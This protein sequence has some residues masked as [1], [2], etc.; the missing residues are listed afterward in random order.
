[1][2][3]SNYAQKNCVGFDDPSCQNIS[4]TPQVENNGENL[5]FY[6][7]DAQALL[8]LE[9]YC[10]YQQESA[11]KY[12]FTCYDGR[13]KQMTFSGTNLQ[14]LGKD[15]ILPYKGD[16]P[17]IEVKTSF[18]T[19]KIQIDDLIN[20]AITV[21]LQKEIDI[22]NAIKKFVRKIN[23]EEYANDCSDGGTPVNPP[24]GLGSWDDAMV[25]WLWKI[26]SQ[27]PNVLCSGSSSGDPNAC[28]CRNMQTDSSLWE[29]DKNFCIINDSVT[30]QRVLNNLG[31]GNLYRT[32]GFGN[33]LTMSILSD[34][35]GNP[36][37]CPPKA[38]RVGYYYPP[39]FPKVRIGIVD[40]CQKSVDGNSFVGTCQW[41]SFIDSYT[42]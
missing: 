5:V 23:L 2:S 40:G 14:T 22:V 10:S 39:T 41:Y 32:D 3:N 36:Q 29:T 37:G 31:L 33:K 20:Y 12:V 30:W 4:L 7:N 24:N 42:E 25:P 16:Y 8:P 34:E 17:V 18:Y 26:V 27:K 19:K 38:P 28:G 13:G 15:Y 21:T 1:M 35:N 9:Q 11:T 6:T